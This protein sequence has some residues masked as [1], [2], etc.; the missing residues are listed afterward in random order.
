MN[1]ILHIAITC[2]RLLFGGMVFGGL[3]LFGCA[4][5][6]WPFEIGEEELGITADFTY[7]TKYIWKGYDLLDDHGAW[8]PSLTLDYRG[9]YAGV[10]GSWA[11]SSGF[12]DADE[13][14]YYLGYA[15]SFFEDQWYAIDADLSW[16]YYDF[17]KSDSHAGDD[18]IS[19]SQEI[20]LV[21]SMSNLIPLGPSN[22]VPSYAVAYDWDGIQSREDVDNGWIHSFGLAYDIPIPALIPGQEEAAISLGWEIVYN[23]GMYGSD[24]GWSHS[25]ATISTAFEW[26]GFTLNPA[27][28]YQWTF[29]DTVNSEDEFFASIS[30]NYAF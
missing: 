29:E 7:V 5:P 4:L 10:W 18:E 24:S 27:V 3:L 25:Q 21:L 13:L 2:I 28:F 9:F 12:V 14:D 1:P 26:Q 30:L 17:P 11:T 8:Q 15:H 19:D 16:Y 20:G 6:A 23:D 22:L